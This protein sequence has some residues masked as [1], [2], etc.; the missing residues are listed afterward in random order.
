MLHFFTSLRIQPAEQKLV[1]FVEGLLWTAVVA[2]LSAVAHVLLGNAT[3]SWTD[4]LKVAG[5]AFVL[6]I[7]NGL[8]QLGSVSPVPLVPPA[9]PPAVTPVSNPPAPPTS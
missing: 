9:T 4:V 1:Q 6:A 8:V 3:F 2:A 5:A 7:G